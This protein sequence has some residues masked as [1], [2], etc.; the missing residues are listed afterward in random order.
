MP[1]GGGSQVSSQEKS[2]KRAVAADFHQ[3]ETPK[4]N[5]KKC[6][7]KKNGTVLYIPGEYLMGSISC[8]DLT[9]DDIIKLRISNG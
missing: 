1:A 5:S 6:L 7:P 9:W 3:L 2:L 4:K 8:I